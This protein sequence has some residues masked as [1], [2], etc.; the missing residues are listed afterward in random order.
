MYQELYNLGLEKASQGEGAGA[1]KE[2][3]RA[4]KVNPQFIDAYYKRAV[5]RFD[6]GDLSR[7]ILSSG[8]CQVC[9]WRLCECDR[10][11]KLCCESVYGVN[12]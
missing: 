5:T 1:I 7:S 3:S 4:L 11:F 12:M 6:F 8:N 2:F 9:N 10:R